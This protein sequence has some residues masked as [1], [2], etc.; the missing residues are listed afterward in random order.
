VL[1]AVGAYLLFAGTV[2]GWRGLTSPYVAALPL[3]AAAQLWLFR[4]ADAARQLLGPQTG[5]LQKWAVP[6]LVLYFP[7]PFFVAL[8]VPGAIPRQRT[9]SNES[10]AI[11]QL[12]TLTA[13]AGR[14]QYAYASGF[15]ASLAVLASP[16]AGA[17][18]DCTA[19]GLLDHF[20]ELRQGYRFEYRPGPPVERAAAGCPAGARSYTV[21]AR[22]HT[23][24]ETGVRS[25][26]AD[27]SGLIRFTRENRAAT[28]VDASL[29]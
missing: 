27:D 15:P 29:R 3:L 5:T 13:A 17:P 9:F 12:R 28:A 4:N 19:S 8:L 6:G 14:Y 2:E 25:F 24:R 11:G 20:T 10:N 18:A 21:G 23:Y 7:L 16:A 1:L 22:P 26:Y